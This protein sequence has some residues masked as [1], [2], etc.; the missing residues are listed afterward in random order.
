MFATSTHHTSPCAIKTLVYENLIYRSS[1]N[2]LALVKVRLRALFWMWRYA[3][4]VCY[5][6]HWG[7]K[8]RDRGLLTQT[9][10]WVAHGRRQRLRSTSNT[11]VDE[12]QI[13]Y[14]SSI[15]LPVDNLRDFLL[16]LVFGL[17]PARLYDTSYSVCKY[18]MF[19]YLCRIPVVFQF[20]LKIKFEFSMELLL[21][22]IAFKNFGLIS[23]VASF[24][25]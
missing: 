3:L 13:S 14:L 11:T 19:E 23:D 5:C 22:N 24:P 25:A 15:V 18:C 16:N 2:C 10:S 6:M 9:T 21:W 7:W 8:G 12:E 4:F 17:I 20:C 1:L